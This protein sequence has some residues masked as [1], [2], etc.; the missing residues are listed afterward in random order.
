MP[1]AFL[2]GDSAQTSVP[3]TNSGITSS[4][5][6]PFCGRYDKC[7]SAGFLSCIFPMFFVVFLRLGIAVIL[8]YLNIF[9]LIY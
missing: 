9:H 4:Q 8:I 1:A 6:F 5:T 7:A 3:A 2:K